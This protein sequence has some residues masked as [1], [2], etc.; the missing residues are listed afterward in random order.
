MFNSFL[1]TLCGVLCVPLVFSQ[2]IS[3][4]G[5]NLNQT[6]GTCDPST[7]QTVGTASVNSTCIQLN[8]AGNFKQGGFWVC[9]SINLNQSFKLNFKSNFGSDQT[10][11]DGIAFVLQEEGLGVIGGTG[12][13]MGYA[14]GNPINCAG[15]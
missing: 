9:N 12:G 10:T 2:S 4:N 5:L 15:G 11:G 7:F 8:A 6:S 3:V 14:N 1:L 13:G